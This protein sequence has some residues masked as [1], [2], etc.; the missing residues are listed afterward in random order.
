ICSI[1]A[2]GFVSIR[3]RAKRF[4]K[5]GGEMVSLAVVEELAQSLW[6]DDVHAALA[7][8]DSRK[9][10]QIVL[11]TTVRA[12]SRADLVA[13]ARAAHVSE[14][15]VPRRVEFMDELPLLGSGKIDYASL[16]DAVH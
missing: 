13:A 5:I 2:R 10:E 1:D 8:A 16:R 15:A 3:G 7:V 11:V 4:A 12:A 9:G 6:P 14:L